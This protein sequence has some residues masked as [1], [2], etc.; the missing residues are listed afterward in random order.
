MT[1]GR[2]AIVTTLRNAGAVLD[3]FIA[4]HLAIGFEHIYLFFDDPADPDLPRLADNPSVS[5]IPHDHALRLRW[6]TIAQYPAQADFI[7]SEVMARQLL[8]VEL[9]MTLARERD[10]GWLLHIDADELF[11]SPDQSAA[12]HFASL[13]SQSCETMNYRNYEAVPE[14]DEIGDFFREVDLFK[15]PPDLCRVPV[16]AAGLRQLRATPQLQPRFFHFYGSGKSAVNLAAPDM[17]PIDVHNFARPNGE[18]QASQSAQ[19]FILHYPC[20]GFETFWT[21]YATLGRFSDQWWNKY[22]IAAL[23][24]PVHLQ[25]RDVVASGDRDAART[26][27]RQRIAMQDRHEIEALM[28]FGFLARF[29]QPLQILRAADAG[30]RTLR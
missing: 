8:N 25:A 19:H 4:Y 16:T 10:L 13:A 6:K 30:M 2:A 12:A 26:F 14:Q 17:Q 23:I 21:K 9:A 11:Y 1:N 22:D 27:Y 3:S 28:E 29:P 15:V 18:Y 24:G 7:D 20:C 5:A